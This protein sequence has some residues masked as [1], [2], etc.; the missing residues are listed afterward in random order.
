M[1]IGCTHM[2]YL[3]RYHLLLQ[4][5]VCKTSILKFSFTLEFFTCALV[6]EYCKL[7]GTRADLI[8]LDSVGVNTP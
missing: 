8:G 6:I 4:I 5:I 1:F 3:L 2:F 7:I